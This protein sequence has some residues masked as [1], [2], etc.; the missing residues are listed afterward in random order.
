M[1]TQFANH[2]TSSAFSLML[3]RTGINH[4][5]NMYAWEKAIIGRGGKPWQYG[6]SIDQPSQHN[7]LL[8]RGLIQ[9]IP[10]QKQE[11]SNYCLTRPGI[12][13]AQML[14]EA[15]FEGS[16]AW[17]FKGDEHMDM[18]FWEL[19]DKADNDKVRYIAE[20]WGMPCLPLH[21]KTERTQLDVE[22]TAALLRTQ[23]PTP[24]T[25]NGY[26]VQSQSR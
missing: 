13:M 20:R 2:A 4:I 5:L 18:L 23:Q 6:M 11:Y 7:Y 24:T 1:H 3:N 12:F 19:K 10:D 25:E 14:L 17:E 21:S 9:L 16:R 15:G 8:R 22:I 26:A